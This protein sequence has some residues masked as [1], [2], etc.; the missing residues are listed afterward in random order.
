MNAQ[1]KVYDAFKDIPDTSVGRFY[2]PLSWLP[3][4]T[5]GKKLDKDQ[6]KYIRV[7]DKNTA[8][9]KNGEILNGSDTVK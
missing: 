5:I 2:K 4:V 1:S 9:T 3:H 7:N 8:E 6:V